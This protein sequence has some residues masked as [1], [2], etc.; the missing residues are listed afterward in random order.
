MLWSLV[1]SLFLF[2][3]NSNAFYLPGVAPTT[4]GEG[5]D[6]PLL[7]N[8]ITPSNSHNIVNSNGGS[9]AGTSQS[10]KA[11]TYVYSF[12]YYFPKLHFCRP[13]D[14]KLEKQS[15][16]LGSIIFGDRIF[17]SPFEIKMLQNQSCT[18]LCSSVYSKTD[19][20][21][22]N[23]IIRSGYY[24]NWLVDGLPIARSLYDTG[25]KTKFYGT[26]FEVGLIDPTNVAHLVNHFDIQIE[27][28]KRGENQ[29]RVVGVTVQ[30][31]SWDR[32][33]SDDQD[34]DKDSNKNL[35][36][37]NANNFDPVFLN[38]NK[39]TEVQFSYS[40]YFVESDI[41][42]ATRWDKYLHVYDPKIQWFSL[43]N[44]S[45]IVLCLS[46][47]I[48]HILL[49]TLKND[50]SKYNSIDLSEDIQEESGWKLVHGDVFRPPINRM[51]LSVMVGSGFQLFLMA[52]V[53]ILFALFGLLSPANRGSLATVMFILYGIFGIFGSFASS[54]IYK[55]F[56]GENWRLNLI[57]T[58]TLVPGT[59][60][61][62]FIGLNFFLIWVKSSGAIPIGTMFAIIGIWFLISLP[63]S[64]IG[65]LLSFKSNN[66]FL[67]KPVKTNQIPRQIPKEPIYLKIW[68]VS[69]ISG[70]FPFGSMAVEIYFIY[71]SIWFNRIYYMFGFL[72]FCFVLMTV[73]C[74]LI[75][76][77]MIYYTLCFENYKWQWR[78]FL[79]SGSCSIYVFIHS[80]F[81]IKFDQ[82]NGAVSIILYLGYSS[83]ISL[84]MFVLCGSIGFISNLIFIRKIYSSIKVD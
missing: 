84:L 43:I 57:L 34:K 51:L 3:F 78:S 30:P 67:K 62:I 68:V 35:C 56:N 48:G 54:F 61:L 40:V 36:D 66:E 32:K 42:W 16:S 58:P 15:E 4:Y 69:L 13:K 73:T 1:L 46:L 45:L 49:K 22:V 2:F 5:D 59:I 18:A 70:I 12:D 71:S 38:Q 7:V 23:K 50:I 83:M 60:F 20:L 63:L 19:T 26:G 33:L 41:S 17:N 65:S 10:K 80:L 31:Y 81:L 72:F 47:V 64:V 8:H 82:L 77:L 6:I 44:F 39:N 29:Y 24:H 79:I 37:A 75:S 27:Y 14:G 53:T 21:F 55:F 25:T 76:I 9:S 28:H 74:S 11:K 52:F